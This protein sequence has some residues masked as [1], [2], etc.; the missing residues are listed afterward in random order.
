MAT[1]DTLTITLQLGETDSSAEVEVLLSYW[2][3]R[4]HIKLIGPVIADLLS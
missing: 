2:P 1:A 3:G 4:L